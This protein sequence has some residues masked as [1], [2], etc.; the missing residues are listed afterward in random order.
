MLDKNS[1]R[2]TDLREL[3]EQPILSDEDYKRVSDYCHIL[4][5]LADEVLMDAR[6][7]IDALNSFKYQ[8]NKMRQG[9]LL[10]RQ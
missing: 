5:V 1:I 6:A 9:Y 10:S 8:L 2:V 4:D 7:R 3:V